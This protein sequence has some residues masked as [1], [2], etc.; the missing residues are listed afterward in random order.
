[1]TGPTTTDHVEDDDV[2][3]DVV[4]DAA[5]VA[6][7]AAAAGAAAG[8]DDE[9]TPPTREEYAA[10]QVKLK[11]SNDEAKAHRLR[12]RE[13]A[14]K[15]ET[16]AEAAARTAREEAEAAAEGRWKPSVVRLAARTALAEAGLIG[17][18]DRLLRMIDTDTVEVDE[19]GEVSG[20]AE[21]VAALKADY[22]ELFTSRR[23]GS[24]VNGAERDTGDSRPGVSDTTRRLLAQARG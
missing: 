11:R 9:W 24:R 15:G 13:L 20:V 3:V 5:A 6:A 21:Q 16:E 18:P 22:P 10:L 14:A 19:D 2:P 8:A 17:K 12:A 4:A 1:M 7:A 23:S